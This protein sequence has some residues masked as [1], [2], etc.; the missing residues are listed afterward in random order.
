MDN[1]KASF[2]PVTQPYLPPLAEFTPYLE[3]IWSNKW[4]T[5]DGPF[6]HQLEQALCEHLG[7]EHVCLFSNGTI[8]LMTALQALD[9]K[10]EVITTPFSFVAT[11]HAL[12]WNGI[13]PV[14]A[15][16]DPVSM[17]LDPAKI[18]AAITPQTTAIL[19]VHVYGNP[20]EIEAI[21]QIAAKHGLR[22]LYDAAHAFGVQRN[23]QSI[24]R[25]GDMS[26]LSFHGTKI[27]HTFEG[28][29]IV[30]RDI[31]TKR[32]IDRLKNFG[33]VDELT[34]GAAGL[35]GKMNE[36]QAAFGML[37]LKHVDYALAARARIDRR[38]RDAL[39][40]VRGLKLHQIESHNTR[41][42]AYFPIRVTPEFPLSRDALFEQFRARHIAVRRYFYPLISEFVTYRDLP[43]A[44]RENLPV[45][46]EVSSQVLCL[47]MYTM[48]E[49]VEQERIIE[50]I[51]SCAVDAKAA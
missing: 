2:V 22:V 33:I 26:I 40:Q 39:G 44:A 34:V 25:A 14:F 13:K 7:V 18:E 49:A 32:R 37:Q 6:H 9:I 28:G 42:H 23:G 4:V 30:C 48:L 19:P 24:L 51:L 17:N 45:A 5:N 31:E 8:A 50:I 36:V 16:I 35:N 46:S 43:S 47:P 21:E 15:D 20:C 3:Q 38:Y 29:A 11:T 12:H 41:N 27:F 10:G 1:Q